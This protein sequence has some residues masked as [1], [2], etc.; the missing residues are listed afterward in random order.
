MSVIL[1]PVFTRKHKPRSNLTI[2]IPCNP[3]LYHRLSTYATSSSF[4]FRGIDS[5]ASCPSCGRV[6]LQLFLSPTTP[7]VRRPTPKLQKRRPSQL[8][9]YHPKNM[10]PLTHIHNITT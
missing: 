2:C 6:P 4:D 5:K 10:Q 9:V 3:G 7:S 8:T 1:I